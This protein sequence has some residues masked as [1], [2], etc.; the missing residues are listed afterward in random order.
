MSGLTNLLDN[1][2]FTSKAL[3][4]EMMFNCV[5]MENNY[6]LAMP[7]FTKTEGIIE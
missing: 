6:Q 7:P 3:H 4:D 1:K 5:N 2:E